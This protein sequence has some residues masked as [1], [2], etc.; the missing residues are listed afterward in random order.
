MVESFGYTVVTFSSA[1]E[2]LASGHL[3]ASACLITDV[4]MPGMDGLELQERL[5]ASGHSI[6]IIFL[7]A[8]PDDRIRERAMI[9][10]AI[11]FLPKPCRRDELLAHIH[12]ALA[13]RAAGEDSP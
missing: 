9:G 1:A 2:L 12:K 6:P 10:G 11:A 5:I 7:T 3:Y 8:F 13:S 4:R